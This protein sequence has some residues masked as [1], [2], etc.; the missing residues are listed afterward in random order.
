MHPVNTD[1]SIL[2]VHKQ[3]SI[4]VS[5]YYECAIKQNKVLH[6]D[7]FGFLRTFQL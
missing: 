6:A 7:L 1:I 5:G 2:Y 3:Y 4:N